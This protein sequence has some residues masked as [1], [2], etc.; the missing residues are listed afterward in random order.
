MHS[1]LAWLSD[2]RIRPILL[3]VLLALLMVYVVM[4]WTDALGMANSPT[5]GASALED[6]PAGD[7]PSVETIP[8]A[9]LLGL[10]EGLRRIVFFDNGLG[11]YEQGLVASSSAWS[12]SEP[13]THGS[14]PLSPRDPG[15]YEMRWW[16]PNGDDVVADVMVFAETSQAGD[17]LIR[18]SS[19]RCRPAG[20]AFAASFPPGGRNLE[21]RNP[22]GFAQEDVY[23]LRGRRVYRVAVVKAG[24]ASSITTGARREAF[25]LVNGLACAL[26]EAACRLYSSPTL[27][28]V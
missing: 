15:G 12:D 4:S 23:L 8:R 10:R 11:P 17:F 26:P 1:R 27:T 7:A 25:S 16:M 3:L 14:Q 28:A 18:A 20:A 6:C 2:E 21:W 22:D 13:G 24:A 19:S 9:R 5:V